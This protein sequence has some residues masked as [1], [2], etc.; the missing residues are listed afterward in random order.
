MT[1]KKLYLLVILLLIPLTYANVELEFQTP[2]GEDLSKH[3]VTLQYGDNVQ[4]SVLDSKIYS[5]TLPDAMYNFEVIVD[6][7]L[8]P[9]PDYFGKKNV[10]LKSSFKERFL[11]FP[12][13]YVQGTV[14]DEQ[15]NL[16]SK[17]ELQFSCYTAKEVSFPK[18]VDK[19]GFF[20]IPNFPEGKCMLI[21]NDGY[22]A[23]RT[24]FLVEKG[25][26]TEVKVVLNEP[27]GNSLLIWPYFLVFLIIFLIGFYLRKRKKPTPKTKEILKKI[28][29]NNAETILKTLSEKEKKVIFFLLENKNK[30]SQSKIR[31]ATKIPRTSLSRVLQKL[32]RKNIISIEKHGKLV[33]IS[34][35]SFFLGEN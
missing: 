33:T 19:T 2:S 11:I 28:Y 3:I 12:I 26:P 15:G 16:V 14:L 22:L 8:T 13:G 4:K 6:N 29:N 18:I 5:L 32:E 10:I 24:E 1:M 34:L 30:T 20:A 9:T 7:P 35:T 27:L 25:Q 21:A 31:H 17:A 23:G